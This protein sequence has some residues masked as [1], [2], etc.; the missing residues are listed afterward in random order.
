[1]PAARRTGE[2]Q[3]ESKSAEE[4]GCQG[5]VLVM[6]QLASALTEIG[7]PGR[8]L[9]TVQT[10]ASIITV[11]RAAWAGRIWEMEQGSAE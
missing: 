3:G 11:A 6:Q 5:D 7:W 1:M 9:I 8:I 2:S 4:R 10:A